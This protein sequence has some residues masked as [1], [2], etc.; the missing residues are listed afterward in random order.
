MRLNAWVFIGSAQVSGTDS[1]IPVFYH[2]R[3]VETRNV[4]SG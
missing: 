1:G 2:L 4:Y 3:T